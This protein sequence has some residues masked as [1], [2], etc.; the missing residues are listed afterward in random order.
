MKTRIFRST[1]LI[2]GALFLGAALASTSGAAQGFA[3]GDAW[4]VG[5][6][7]N[8]NNP[9]HDNAIYT[10]FESSPSPNLKYDIMFMQMQGTHALQPFFCE[11]GPW[12]NTTKS[13]SCSIVRF[14]SDDDGYLKET[15]EI[16][17]LVGDFCKL[18][19]CEHNPATG[20]GPIK[21]DGDCHAPGKCTCYEIR[22]ECGPTDSGPWDSAA[23]PD[24]AA[25]VSQGAE[26]ESGGKDTGR[27]PPGRGAGTGK[28]N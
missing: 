28:T 20:S 19:R 4:Y 6:G 7:E 8:T 11:D 1:R 23:C 12:V 24:P 14:I 22:H 10:V 26:S 25:L 5:P 17:R 3:N 2:T 27:A 15:V 16:G 13:A 9:E 21:A 18:L